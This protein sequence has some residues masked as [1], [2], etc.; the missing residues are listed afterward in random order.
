[1]IHS[2]LRTILKKQRLSV[3]TVSNKTGIGR[4]TL[5]SLLYNTGNGIQFETLE[6]LCYFLKIN[7]NDLFT[8]VPFNIGFGIMATFPNGAEFEKIT[9]DAVFSLTSPL[10]DDLFNFEMP[11]LISFISHNDSYT[12]FIKIDLSFTEQHEYYYQKHIDS[13]SKDN[14]EII[15]N[16]V[17]DEIIQFCT[18]KFKSKDKDNKPYALDLRLFNKWDKFSV[19]DK[20]L[21]EIKDKNR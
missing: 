2:N 3:S 7:I 8:Y 17:K 1:M 14:I 11:M 13:F 9:G 6:K 5:T 21:N 19:Y 15:K 4:T 20:L 18:S 16:T 12:G 10:E